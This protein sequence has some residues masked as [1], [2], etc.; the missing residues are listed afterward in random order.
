MRGPV[1][2]GL[3]QRG[4]GGRADR[5]GLPRRRRR[6]APRARAGWLGSV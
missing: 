1:P 2:P 3:G 4:A 6:Q 5:R